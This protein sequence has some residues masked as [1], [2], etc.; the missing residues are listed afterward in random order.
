MSAADRELVSRSARGDVEA[1]RKLVEK[2]S[3]LV[4]RV[5]L[6]MLG[7]E[8]AQDASQDVW[9]RVWKNI[10]QFRGESAFSTW[11]Y[12]ITVNACLNTRRREIRH[13]KR[14]RLEEVP[15]LPE[16]AGGD[17]DPEAATLSRERREELNAALGKLRAEHRAAVILRHLEGLSYDEIAEILEVPNGTAK[18]WASRGRAALL[19]VLSE[20]GSEERRGTSR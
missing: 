10:K 16:P 11:L 20:E 1:F 5:A 13:E 17:S 8:E 7:P 18:G 3:S 14:E 4:Y 9:V 19:V 12:R 6:R 2:H 15:Y